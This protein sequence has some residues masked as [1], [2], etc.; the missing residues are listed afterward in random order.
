[1]NNL[2]PS[3]IFICL[4][5]SS[6][7]MMFSLDGIGTISNVLLL[8]LIFVIIIIVLLNGVPIQVN[9]YEKMGGLL[10][11]SC[12]FIFNLIKFQDVNSLS[13]ALIPT[14]IVMFFFLVIAFI[15]DFSKLIKALRYYLIFM[16][17]ILFVGFILYVFVI[18]GF[19][20]SSSIVHAHDHANALGYVSVYG[21]LYYPE[22]I[23]INIA[24]FEIYR[25]T[26]IFWEP[27]TLGLY[28]IFL[29]SIERLFFKLDRN[30]KYRLI[31]F[32][33]GGFLSLSLLFFICAIALT[34]IFDFKTI[35]I[36]SLIVV[37]LLL[38]LFVSQFNYIN[39][40]ILYR[41]NYDPTR[42]FVGNNRSG[43]ISAFWEQFSSGN[44][45]HQLFGFGTE[46]FDGDSTSFVIKLFQRG[47][48][49]FSLLILSIL[50]LGAN[51]SKRILFV[52][53]LALSVLCQIEGALFAIMLFSFRVYR[54][55]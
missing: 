42:G 5:L 11:F 26:S 7:F 23:K 34:L 40:L 1:M 15:C 6:K 47:I 9:S 31:I 2:I 8:I 25:F 21:L 36:R 39:E 22:W 20:N 12:F 44:I 43:V 50:M 45:W 33:I 49:G 4:L 13:H 51:F 55:I 17:G 41:L 18:L 46:A 30:S 29:I 37:L 3:L 53:F 28:M 54:F 19:I 32:Y 24:S 35:K 14:N 10:F 38:L 48:I 16:A 27:G 52:W